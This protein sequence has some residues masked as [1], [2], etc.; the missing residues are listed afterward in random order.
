MKTSVKGILISLSLNPLSSTNKDYP[1]QIPQVFSSY[2]IIY[3]LL[4][5]SMNVPF[6]NISKI[7][8]LFNVFNQRPGKPACMLVFEPNDEM[9]AGSN[10]NS[11]V[12]QQSDVVTLQKT[13][14]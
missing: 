11:F 8:L 12:T 1:P 13:I 2:S 7:A 10:K 3:H 9:L 6:Y 14:L 5:L 4:H